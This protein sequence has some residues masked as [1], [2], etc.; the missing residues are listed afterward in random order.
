VKLPP[1]P[2][3]LLLPST[4]DAV[5]QGEAFRLKAANSNNADG[6]NSLGCCL[7][8]GEGIEKDIDQAV[9]N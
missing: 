5:K 8:K 7:E 2:P 9:Q 1:I 4:V 3:A 6:A